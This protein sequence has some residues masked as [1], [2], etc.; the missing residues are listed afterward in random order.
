M[1]LLI[2]IDET[3][4]YHHDP[5]SK[6][7]TK[8]KYESGCSASKLVHAENWPRMLWRPFFGMRKEHG[9]HIL[10]DLWSKCINVQGDYTE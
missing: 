6:Q 9:I 5:Q 7:E 2:T 10:E 8:E 1:R 3:R 4:V